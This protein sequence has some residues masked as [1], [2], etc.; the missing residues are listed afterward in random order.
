MNA[1][2]REVAMDDLTVDQLEAL[3]REAELAHG[4]FEQSL[5]HR[6]DNWPRWYAD[7]ILNKVHEHGVR[8]AP[9]RSR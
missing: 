8:I 2:E 3:L 5:G 7:Y 9:E 4:A 6:D 1:H